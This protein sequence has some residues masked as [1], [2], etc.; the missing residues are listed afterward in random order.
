MERRPFVRMV[1]TF[2]GAA[3][4]E[5]LG[6]DLMN[7][8]RAMQGSRVSGSMLEETELAVLRFHHLYKELPPTELFPHVQQYLQAVT[9]LLE[10]SQTIKS[11][12]DC[13]P[14]LDISLAF[15]RGSP[16]TWATRQPPTS[17][18]RQR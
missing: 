16:S 15:E 10:E 8:L 11:G 2:A 17:G 18:T 9:G 4:L 5:A 3:M 7:L 6:V 14:S 12:A 13:A 1:G